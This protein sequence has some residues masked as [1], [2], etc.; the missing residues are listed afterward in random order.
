M[1]ATAARP[2][3]LVAGEKALAL[4]KRALV[5]DCTALLYTVD[6]PYAS[7]MA[8]GGVDAVNL[9]TVSETESWDDTL[10]ITATVLNKIAKS[11]IL[12]LATTAAEVRAAKKAG[13]IAVILGT[14]GA[15]MLDTQLWRLEVLYHLG[16]RYFGLAYTG[17]NVFA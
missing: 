17:A 2:K 4:H 9:T 12:T 3:D 16:Y 6:E 7:R 13:K 15:S 10:R 8:E 5:F 14:Q 11:S 1:S